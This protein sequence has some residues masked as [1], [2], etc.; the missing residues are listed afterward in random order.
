MTNRIAD[1]A[2]EYRFIIT[3]NV[4]PMRLGRMFPTGWTR[5]SRADDV[6]E[7]ATSVPYWYDK[8]GT[9]VTAAGRVTVAEVIAR[10]PAR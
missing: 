5:L 3:G 1:M 4:K 8:R 7:V 2:D 6:C 10:Q 9:K